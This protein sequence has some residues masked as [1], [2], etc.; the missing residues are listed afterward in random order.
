MKQERRVPVGAVTAEFDGV[1]LGD[2]RL[3]RR[4]PE[5]VGRLALEPS[6]SF[7]ALMVTAKE[8]E[9]FYRFLRNEKVT[10]PSLL[11][12]HTAATAERAKEWPVVVVAHDTTEVAF[13]GSGRSELYELRSGTYGFAV[14]LSL[15]IGFGSVPCPLGAVAVSIQSD[16]K[17]NRG[18]WLSQALQAD[19]KLEGMSELV[20]VMDREADVYS[21][22]AGLIGDQARFVVRA[23]HDRLLADGMGQELSLLEQL[24]RRTKVMT[25]REVAISARRETAKTAMPDERKAR[26]PRKSR[27]AR[28]AIRACSITIPR[29]QRQDR[30]APET[31]QINVVEAREL[32]PPRGCEPVHWLLATTEPIE[33][34]EDVLKVVD[35]YRTRWTIEEYFKALKTGCAYES[36]QLE[37]LDTFTVALGLFIPIAWQLLLLKSQSR[38][39][40]VPARAVMS[41]SRLAILRAL[42]AHNGHQIPLRAD[43]CDVMKAVARLGGHLLQN[44]E[45]GWQVLW[46]GYKKVLEAEVVLAATQ[47]LRKDTINA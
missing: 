7:P 10:L 19:S 30:N 44:G 35:L 14:H 46:R 20:H 3:D 6:A 26:P 36:R 45:P 42:C 31:I 13:K 2:K 25:V 27:Q 15:A 11:A 8:Q 18:R 43:A 21:L 12:P 34:S 9:A 24:K 32:K 17:S 16:T 33:T 38:L 1:D 4:V 5:I 37:Q 28:L 39:P 29:P 23:R 47:N 22:F 40:N 41:S